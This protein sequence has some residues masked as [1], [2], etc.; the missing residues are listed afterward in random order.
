MK[1][2]IILEEKFQQIGGTCK[3]KEFKESIAKFEV[4]D[5]V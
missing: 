2:Y 4:Q 3:A 5:D 1:E